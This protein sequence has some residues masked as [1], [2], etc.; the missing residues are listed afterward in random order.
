MA[1]LNIRD[2]HFLYKTLPFQIYDLTKPKAGLRRKVRGYIHV[3]HG[4]IPTAIRPIISALKL[5]SYG[6]STIASVDV[7][8]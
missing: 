4:N 7:Q 6:R 2:A 1:L 5:Y 8:P 3:G